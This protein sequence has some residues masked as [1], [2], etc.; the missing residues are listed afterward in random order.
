M[1]LS[2]HRLIS[3]SFCRL[4]HQDRRSFLPCKILLLVLAWS[5]SATADQTAGYDYFSGNRDMIRN[6]VQAV[7]M[8]NGLFTSNRSREQ[9]F[10]Q[11]LAYMVKFGGAVGDVSAGAYK[12]NRADRWVMVGGGESGTAIRAVFRT[13]LEH[14][15]VYSRLNTGAAYVG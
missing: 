7:L 2:V 12:V 6:G 3:L 1:T 11:E 8:C 5:A 10:E 13:G 14:E 4:N 9:V 15:D